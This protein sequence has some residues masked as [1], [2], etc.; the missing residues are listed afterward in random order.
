MYVFK[1]EMSERK[2]SFAVIGV[3]LLTLIVAKNI[4]E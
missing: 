3:W 2:E 4:L 1:R